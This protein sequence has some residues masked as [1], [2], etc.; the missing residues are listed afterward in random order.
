M[1][2]PLN[3][4]GGIRPRLTADTLPAGMAA[5]VFDANLD[6]GSI[7][8][9]V[10]SLPIARMNDGTSLIS[11]VPAGEVNAITPPG[12]ITVNKKDWTCQ[13][14]AGAS[15]WLV[16]VKAYAWAVY[17]DGTLQQNYKLTWTPPITSVENTETGFKLHVNVSGN[18]FTFAANTAYAIYGP[19]FQFHFRN[20]TGDKGGPVLESDLWLPD[21][22]AEKFTDPFVPVWNLELWKNGQSYADLRAC[23]LSGNLWDKESVAFSVGRNYFLDGG[24]YVF[25]FL[26]DY[27][28]PR[29]KVRRFVQTFVDAGGHQ[30]PASAE[31][32]LIQTGPGQ[33]PTLNL[34]NG[35]GNFPAGGVRRIWQAGRSFDRS[36]AARHSSV[37][38]RDTSPPAAAAPPTSSCCAT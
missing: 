11:A 18:Q 16:E 22:G 37:I 9:L 25:E 28:D 15:P 7:R 17:F 33:I 10:I 23:N 36:R 35:S 4:Y 30:S 27:A 31:S 6:G 29:R 24:E 5:E 14:R 34:P 20:D 32:D 26:L 38:C 21:Q 8:P 1:S 13:P 12:K 2:I 19:R 3:R